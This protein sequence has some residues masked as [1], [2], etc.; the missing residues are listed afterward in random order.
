MMTLTRWVATFPGSKNHL[1]YLE[2]LDERPELS[3]LAASLRHEMVMNMPVTASHEVLRMG[4]FSYTVDAATSDVYRSSS[5][6]STDASRRDVREPA[7]EPE[8]ELV[9]RVEDVRP[10]ARVTGLRLSRSGKE[11]AVV[12]G[13]GGGPHVYVVDGEDVG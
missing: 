1:E 4:K 12:L 6:S 8:P 2:V 5:V 11:L 9:F 10:G 13:W 3:K 7:P